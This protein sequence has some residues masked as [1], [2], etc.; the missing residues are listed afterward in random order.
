MLSPEAEVTIWLSNIVYNTQVVNDND[1]DVVINSNSLIEEKLNDLIRKIEKQREEEKRRQREQPSF[2]QIPVLDEEGNQV[3]DE[4]G[5]PVMQEVPDTTMSS[6]DEEPME[7]DI[8]DTDY[9][10]EARAEAERILTEAKEEID[11]M[12][13]EA[14]AE[15][16]AIRKNAEV[17]GH[18]EGYQAGI[19][20][21]AQENTAEKERLMNQEREMLSHIQMKEE[22]MEKELVDTLCDVFEKVF[23]IQFADKKEILY[24][25]AE[26]AVSHIEGSKILQV[27]VNE[28]GREF[29]STKK[30]EI[31]AKVGEDVQ[32]DIIMDPVL[33]DGD[34]IIE[35]DGGIFDCSLGTEV[36]NLIKDIRSLA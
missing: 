11:R 30:D 19:T 2:I 25:L 13:A 28:A 18:N 12:Y 14:E 21:A 27:R 36:G 35:T 34:C 29:L 1:E 3:M 15:I 16:A 26:N 17:E 33:Q 20:R 9:V 8:P 24:H 4:E 6:D 10:E 32:V 7:A 31:K 5:N 22:R 23:M